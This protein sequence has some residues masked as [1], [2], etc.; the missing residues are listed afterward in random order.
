MDA[1]GATPMSRASY[2][3]WTRAQ[4]VLLLLLLGIAATPAGRLHAQIDSMITA[5]A[6]SLEIKFVDVDLRAAVQALGRYLDRPVIVGNVN[7]VRIT[8]ETP[9]PVIRAEIPRLL[10]GLLESQNILLVD[11]STAGVYRLEIR[12]GDRARNQPTP[13]SAPGQAL[14][15]FV[16]RLRHAKA[17]DVAAS[18]NALYG[19]ASALGEIGSRPQTLSRNLEGQRVPPVTPS[20][21]PSFSPQ[22]PV[23]R[24]ASLASDVVI[25]PDAR[26]NSL[27]IRASRSD[28][29]LLQAAVEQIDIRPLQVL[30]EVLIAELRRDRTLDF[31]VGA[32]LPPTH[33]KG[34]ENT[35]IQGTTIGSGVSDFILKVMGM[36]GLDIEATLRAAASRGDATIVSRPVLL[37]ANNEPAEINVGTQRPFVQVARVLPTDNTARDQVVQYKD[38]GT[39]LQVIPTISADDYIMLQVTQEINAATAEQAFDAPVISTRSVDTKLLVRDGQ[40]IVLGGLTDHQ[41]ERSQGGVPIL[42]SIP[43]IGGVFGR[44]SRRASETELFLFLTPRIIRDDDDADFITR[45]LKRKAEKIEHE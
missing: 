1:D 32:S 4:W 22:G 13:T 24:N 14:E 20:G 43:W 3:G 17:A 8:L 41:R 7:S 25:V 18:V 34:T 36:G 19:R 16:I 23:A 2:H 33:I 38:V 39:R 40:T 30:I 26:A 6:D 15:L 10:R 28:F 37:A 35:T 11:D 12:E 45:E 44:V 29:A 31:G 9:R 42:S 21:Q 5:R 27:L